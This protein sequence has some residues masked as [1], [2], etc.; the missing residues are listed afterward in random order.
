[1][2]PFFTVK[3]KDFSLVYRNLGFRNLVRVAVRNLFDI[4]HYYILEIRLNDKLASPQMNLNGAQMCPLCESDLKALKSQF[5]SLKDH[6]RK[7]LMSRLLFYEN[8]FRNCYALKMKG[9]IAYLQW[10]IYPEENNLILGKY[11]SRFMPLKEKQVMLENSFTFPRYRGFG[12]MLFGTLDLLAKAR[13][14]GYNSAVCYALKENVAA[15]NHLAQMGFKIRR[16]IREYK[17]FGHVWRNF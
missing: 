7:E 15:L 6:D 11:G 12:V 2:N 1:M 3:P 17:I 16:I 13:D 8:G 10:I 4:N 9:D 14:Q 5:P